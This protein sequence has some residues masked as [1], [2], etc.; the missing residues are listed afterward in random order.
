M[1]QRYVACERRVAMKSEGVKLAVSL[2]S[3][4][5]NEQVIHVAGSFQSIKDCDLREQRNREP[6]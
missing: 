3:S 6:W 2:E 4:V 5:G 1:L